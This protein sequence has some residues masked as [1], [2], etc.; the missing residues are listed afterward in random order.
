MQC[1]IMVVS[2]VVMWTT[3]DLN[4]PRDGFVVMMIAS[5]HGWAL[6]FLVSALAGTSAIITL[7]MI[8]PSSRGT[9]FVGQNSL[10]FLGV[11]GLFFHFLNQRLLSGFAPADNQFAV[12]AYCTVATSISLL[13][14][15]P[16]V[17]LLRKWI[18]QLV[19]I[20]NCTG[21]ILPNLEL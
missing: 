16:V 14:S 10:I 9:L 7:S 13:M 5:N 20:P 3:Y 12:L 4:R 15:S 11:N 17:M 1:C 19:G 2:A 6:P 18:P 21:P 8:L